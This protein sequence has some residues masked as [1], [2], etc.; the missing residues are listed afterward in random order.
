MLRMLFAGGVVLLASAGSLVAENEP[1]PAE[2]ARLQAAATALDEQCR[3]L[4]A[5]APDDRH[6]ADAALCAKAV[7]WTLRHN[8]FYR[9]ETVKWLNAALELGQQRAADLAAGKEPWRMRPGVATVLGYDS[10][11]DGSVQ[12]YAVT[13][14]KDFDP[15]A[16][17]RWPLHVVLHGR[18]DTLTEAQFLQQFEGKAPKKDLAWIQLDV[19]G[20]TNNAYRWSGET[21]V[22]EAYSAVVKNYPIDEHRV[23]LWG[24]SMGGAGAWH[25]GLHHPDRWSSVG[26][27]AGFVD[28][29]K[30]LKLPEPLSPLHAK[31]VRIYDATEYALNAANVPIIG[32]AGDQDA[33]L[34]AAQTMHDL[35]QQAGVSIPLLVGPQTGHKFHPD[36]ER[37]FFAFHAA[38]TEK[39]RPPFPGSKS[40][41]FTTCTVKYHTCEWLTVEEQF[42]PYAPS[43]V[44]ATVD[45]AAD[46][47]RVTTN[48][49]AV[50]Q[51][52]RD[53]AESAQ[54]DNGMLLPLTSA[55]GG[56]LPG[57]YYERRGDEWVALSYRESHDYLTKPEGRKRHNLQ[58][59]IDDAFMQPFVCVRGTGTPWSAEHEQWARWTLSRFGR[60]Y[61]RWLRA[62]LPILNDSQV[63]EEQIESQHLVLFGDPGSNSVLA[64]VVDKLPLQ[65]TRRSLE[66]RGKSYDPAQTGVP[67]I[68]QNPLNP[69]RYVVLNSGHTFHEPE[70][71][72]SNAQLYPRLGDIAA[73]QFRPQPDGAFTE[74]VL[75]AEV[76]NNRWELPPAD[77]R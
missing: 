4:R 38:A 50:L 46:V 42:E 75:W 47:V 22:F 36:S 19:F 63:T 73:V 27:G 25:L 5:D 33:Q 62:E 48:N 9:P 52:A 29:V 40:L 69:H 6:I 41:R 53:V 30:Y 24:F 10:A 16:R 26:A 39:G 2:S 37:E 20:R 49:V 59:P 21:D 66:V 72:A 56:L 43:V 68:Y 70:F 58:G 55:A 31:L 67:L 32:Y 64:K 61:D 1:A 76:F 51:L 7:L 74:T 17:R 14:P 77:P 45:D 44:E 12:P 13:L 8:Q 28:T 71:K 60:E 23:T 54:I 15:Q 3:R 18:N 57:V 35:G 11:V 34:L 65:W